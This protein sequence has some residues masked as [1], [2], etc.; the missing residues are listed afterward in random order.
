M[1]F[2]HWSWRDYRETPRSRVLAALELMQEQARA[3]APRVEAD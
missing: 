1:K 2:M 3:N